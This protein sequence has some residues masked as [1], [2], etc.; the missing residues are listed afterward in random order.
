MNSYRKYWHLDG[1]VAFL[2]HGSFGATPIPV[3]EAQDDFRRRMER[4]PVLF[5]DRELP[6]LLEE[7]RV[8]VA[9]FVHC[10]P[11]SLFFVENAT[12]GVNTVLQSVRFGP[13]DEILMT[14]HTY[15]AC[16]N[17]VLFA[18]RESGAEVRI[19]PI[20]FPCSGSEELAQAI[21]SGVT[22]RTRLVLL[23]HVTSPTAM[24][25]PVETLVRELE[26]KG[27]SVLVDGAHSPGM[28]PLDLAALG[29][30]Y[31]VGN[32]H[33]WMCGPKGAAILVVRKDLHSRMRPLVISHGADSGPPSSERLRRELDWV[34]TRDW[35]AVLA[36][37]RTIEFLEALVPGGHTAWMESN[38]EKARAVR[39]RVSS[40]LG[41]SPPCPV[42]LLGSMVA[43]PLPQRFQDLP[44]SPSGRD[45]VQQWLWEQHRI[46]TVVLTLC[47]C[48]ILRL[49]CQVYNDL[50]EYEDLCDV[51]D[52]WPGCACG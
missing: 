14:R 33:K 43:L 4:Q 20:P 34:G 13:G 41:V 37:P 17:A 47:G 19:V 9:R 21:R 49:S 31:F 1:E 46:E 16:A 30:S 7:S 5:L 50:S 52:I 42:G 2:N 3:L 40:R 51:L 8:A 10:D 11:Y 29:A 39:Q 23:D 26:S 36:L 24:V 28:L 35:T 6:G 12:V 25:F 22:P 48:R 32:C 15:H 44:L 38:S 27:I 45:P 18:S